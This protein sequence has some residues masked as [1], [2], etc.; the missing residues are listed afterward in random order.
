MPEQT[1][2]K[3]RLYRWLK[4]IYLEQL[5]DIGRIFFWIL[6]LAM[7]IGNFSY[8]VMKIYLFFCVLIGFFVVSIVLAK[9]SNVNLN[10]NINFPERVTCFSDLMLPLIIKNNTKK[11]ALDITIRHNEFPHEVQFHPNEGV[12]INS[13][14]PGEEVTE[15]IEIK[16]LQRGHY[17]LE[18]LKQ[19][20]I[21]PWGLCRNTII[22]RKNHSLLVYPK[23]HPL[24]KIDIPAG[25]RYQLGGIALSSYLG[26]STEFIN[27]REFKEGDSIRTIHWRSWARIGKPVVK[28]FQEEYFCRI[29]LLLDT[30]MPTNS[31]KNIRPAF[32]A[33]VSISAAIADRL[34]KEEYVIDLFAAGPEIY[35][36]QAGRSLAYLE[37]ILDI[38]ACIEPCFEQPF[39]KI[40]PILL[41]NLGNVTTTIVILLDWDEQ[42]EKMIR[43]IREQG[44][45][46]KV[47][48]VKDT[49]ALL[50]IL[51]AEDL[52]GHVT[53]ITSKEEE[54]GIEEL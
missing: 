50:D 41:D 1:A 10:L 22:H 48:L 19:D 40:T 35:Y 20:T 3:F 28:E 47:I 45:A 7:L 34:S 13:I 2:A 14:L 8:T 24:R 17:I 12:Y 54:L 15:N 18:G 30:F 9:F 36:L 43:T 46:V 49:P 38:L 5:T 39:K 32:E 23:F 51:A 16:F 37:N 29:A 53:Q 27:T 4:H 52:T 42:R 25:K 11:E 6:I 26:D 44:S 33:A 21:F 31:A